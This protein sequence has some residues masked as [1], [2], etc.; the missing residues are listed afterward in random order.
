[1]DRIE[2]SRE[3]LLIIIGA[4]LALCTGMGWVCSGASPGRSWP[5]RRGQSL[6]KGDYSIEVP[7]T[8]SKDE[9]GTLAR[10]VEVLKQGAAAMR[11][12]AV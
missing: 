3:A 4:A 10:A 6:A 12:S 7:Y 9:L 2:E 1:M 5:S 8:G 11:G